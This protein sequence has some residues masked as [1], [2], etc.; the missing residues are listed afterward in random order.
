MIGNFTLKL[1]IF[2]LFRGGGSYNLSL[3]GH[4]TRIIGVEPSFEFISTISLSLT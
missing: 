3:A 1:R 4:S 2:I